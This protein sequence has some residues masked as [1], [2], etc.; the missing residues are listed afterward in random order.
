[1]WWWALNLLSL[2]WQA[3]R[4]LFYRRY[5]LINSLAVQYLGKVPRAATYF[6]LE[7]GACIG[8]REVDRW[9]GNLGNVMD[10]YCST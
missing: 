4:G 3:T 5:N 10:L 9:V 7:K 2:Q 6:V 8:S 1:M